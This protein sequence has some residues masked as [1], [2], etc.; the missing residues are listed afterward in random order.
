VRTLIDEE[1][2]V[3]AVGRVVGLR[4]TPGCGATVAYGG[5]YRGL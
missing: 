1:Q 3:I 4:V 5:G 2:A